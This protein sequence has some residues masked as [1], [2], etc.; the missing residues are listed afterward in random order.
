[1]NV[2]KIKLWCVIG[3]IPSPREYII[4]ADS[5][6]FV[7][8]IMSCNIKKTIHISKFLRSKID[9]HAFNAF[10]HTVRYSGYTKSSLSLLKGLHLQV[11]TEL[12]TIT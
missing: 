7:N 6:S 3:T 12:K 2:D 4:T 8:V 9:Q 10:S 5:I 11:I 1:M